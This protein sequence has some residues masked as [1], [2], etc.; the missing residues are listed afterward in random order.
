M[1]RGYELEIVENLLK[2]KVKCKTEQ[3]EVVYL[4]ARVDPCHTHCSI[5]LIL[6]RTMARGSKPETFLTVVFSSP[7]CHALDPGKPPSAFA[8]SHKTQ[9]ETNCTQMTLTNPSHDRFTS[10]SI[11][12][13]TISE[14]ER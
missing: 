2:K 1:E 14:S 8:C 5:P 13:F 4:G 7:T 3:V 9:P 10:S 11:A 12:I 6:R